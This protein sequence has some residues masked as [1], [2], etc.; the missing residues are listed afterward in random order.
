MALSQ[1]DRLSISEKLIDIP[2]EDAAADKVQEIINENKVQ[3]EKKDEANKNLMDAQTA[4]INPY[5]KELTQYD[6]NG[7][8]E[9][10]EQDVIDSANKIIQNPFYPNDPQNTIPSLSDGVWKN[11]PPFA[12]GKAIGKDY[13]EAYTTETK[14]QDKIDAVNSAIAAVEALPSGERSSGK[15]CNVDDSGSCSGETPP[16]SGVDETTCTTNG[17][18]WTPTNGPD[19][20][21]PSTDAQTALDNLVTALNDWKAFVTITKGFNTDEN[22]V[23]TDATRQGQNNT[24]IADIDNLVAVIDSWFAFQDFDVTTALPGGSNGSGCALFAALPPGDFD[25]SKLREDEIQIIK[26]EITARQAFITTRQSEVEA[27]LGSISQDINSGDITSG[28]GFYNKRYN[29][30]DLRLNLVGGTKNIVEANDKGIAAQ[31]QLKA[32]N[33]RAA[34]A[35]GDVM[36]LSPLK[37]PAAG[38]GTLHVQDGSGFSVGDTVYVAAAK[39][40]ELTG[41]VQEVDGNRV[42]L[43]INIPKKYTNNNKGRLYK[44]L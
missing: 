8:T 32:T 36:N 19:T 40:A 33:A 12:L 13:F 43:D 6:G 15:I 10:V 17:G 38:T 29:F 31:D 37:A 39:Q 28:T 24:S 3:F 27:N 41:T 1:D 42:V 4:L 11:F 35:Y 34:G 5:Q 23:D 14:E 18:T 44:L 30:L 26:D 9:L 22:A 21:V 25:P 2:A 7:R 20:Y 16:G